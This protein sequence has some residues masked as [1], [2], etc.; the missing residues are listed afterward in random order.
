MPALLGIRELALLVV[1]LLIF[2]GAKRLP[3]IGHSLGQ[4]LREFKD[5]I[6]GRT[7]SEIGGKR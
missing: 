2:F 1:V 4:G 7:K 5:G 3:E 6:T